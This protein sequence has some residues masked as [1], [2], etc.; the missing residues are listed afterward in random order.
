MRPDWIRSSKLIWYAAGIAIAGGGLYVIKPLVT[1]F[2]ALA[3][4]YGAMALIGLGGRRLPAF[5]NWNGF[6][7]VSRLSYGMYLNHLNNLILNTNL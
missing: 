3:L 6:Y 7:F 4:I 5:I 1:N 2:A